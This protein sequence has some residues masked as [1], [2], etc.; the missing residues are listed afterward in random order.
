MMYDLEDF[1][2]NQYYMLADLFE[3]LGDNL[4]PP[5]MDAAYG[6]ADYFTRLGDIENNLAEIVYFNWQE[7]TIPSISEL[8]D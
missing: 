4:P 1:I 2:L 6:M 8:I 7:S 5:L 3:Q